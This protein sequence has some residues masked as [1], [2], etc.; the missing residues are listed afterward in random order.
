MIDTNIDFQLIRDAFSNFCAC[1]IMIMIFFFKHF[2]CW[3][4]IVR[5]WKF[6]KNFSVQPLNRVNFLMREVCGILIFVIIL[7]PILYFHR[8][9]IFS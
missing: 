5:I 7:L 2:T 1:E 6:L 3:N 4:E 9:L 8:F